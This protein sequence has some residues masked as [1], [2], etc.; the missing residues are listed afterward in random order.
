MENY[1]DVN[2]ERYISPIEWMWHAGEDFR[3]FLLS[4]A[5]SILCPEEFTPFPGILEPHEV[6][7]NMFFLISFTMIQGK[8]KIY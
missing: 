1:V 8:S 4:F 5:V 7:K 6:S 3:V 2:R